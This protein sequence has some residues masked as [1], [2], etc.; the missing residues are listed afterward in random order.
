MMS[1]MGSNGAG[2]LFELLEPLAWCRP[3]P[4]GMAE[5]ALLMKDEDF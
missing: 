2:I 4:P 5:V 3:P 1:K